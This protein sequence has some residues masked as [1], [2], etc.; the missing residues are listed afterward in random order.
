MGGWGGGYS[1][2]PPRV[3]SAELRFGTSTRAPANSQDAPPDI[4]NIHRGNVRVIEGDQGQG[5]VRE[6][7]RHTF[8]LIFTDSMHRPTQC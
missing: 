4:R 1:W 8:I 3:S 6:M 7:F 2:G 5:P